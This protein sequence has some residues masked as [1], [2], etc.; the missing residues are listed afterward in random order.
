MHGLLPLEEVVALIMMLETTMVL[1]EQ[2]EQPLEAQVVLLMAKVV[3]MVVAV[4]NLV[5]DPL[6]LAVH[7]LILVLLDQ[8]SKGATEDPV[9][10]VV[11]LVAVAAVDASKTM[12]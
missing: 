4:L 2:V 11:H 5:V 7:R 9:A 3:V 6:D 10:V 1:V 12:S 8:L